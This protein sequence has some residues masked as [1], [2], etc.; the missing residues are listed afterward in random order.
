M[1]LAFKAAL[2]TFD[3]F[4]RDS[5]AQLAKTFFYSP[6]CAMNADRAQPR[7]GFQADEGDMRDMIETQR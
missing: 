4:N 3:I 2:Q 5:H 1:G 6:E 7:P